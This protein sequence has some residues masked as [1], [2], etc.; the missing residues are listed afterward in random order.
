MAEI[1][2]FH[3]S[4]NTNPNINAE[5][6][7]QNALYF[8]NIVEKMKL[9]H[10]ALLR[11]NNEKAIQLGNVIS[12]I[13]NSVVGAV[14]EVFK[15]EEFNGQVQAPYF[16]Q[17]CMQSVNAIFAGGII[18]PL[19]GS[20]EEWIDTTVPD[21][22]GQEFHMSYRGEE[23]SI[24][25]ESVQVNKRY[26]KIYRLNN[27]NNL[28]HRID[29]FQFHDA[30]NPDHVHLTEDSIRFIQFPYTM[31]SLH[32]HCIIE[33][34]AI[35]D[36]LDFDYTDI[37]DGLIY[38]DQTDDGQYSYVIAPKIPF[39]MLE[40][41]GVSLEAE[42]EEYL[43]YVGQSEIDDGAPFLPGDDFGDDHDDFVDDFDDK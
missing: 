15:D 22:I 25:I 29:Y 41:A 28:A 2:K 38:P 12:V 34:N 4:E 43:Q 31:K 40:E 13:V 3:G 35:T 16:L 10:E 32:S 8:N 30:K 9:E 14:S 39:T 21:D 5:I 36:Y 33:E 7:K 23:Y 42:I 18:S 20:D 37:K 26:P 24:K 17:Q 19:T 1:L 11:T 27:D 6:S